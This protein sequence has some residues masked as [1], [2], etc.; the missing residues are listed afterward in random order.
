MHMYGVA[1]GEAR[2]VDV[3]QL[4][5]EIE[6]LVE[7]GATQVSVWGGLYATDGLCHNANRGTY[8]HECGKPAEWLG[9]G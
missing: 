9:M 4:P 6:S 7:R 2:E 5:A 1:E 8:G 3:R